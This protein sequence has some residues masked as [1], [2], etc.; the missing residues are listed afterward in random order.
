MV[1]HDLAR[2]EIWI[3]DFILA[4]SKTYG[5]AI[6]NSDPKMPELV[7]LYAIC[8]GPSSGVRI[9]LWPRRP[10]LPRVRLHG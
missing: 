7:D 8:S 6:V 9:A 5:D 3:R 2:R 4:A 1:A 10:R